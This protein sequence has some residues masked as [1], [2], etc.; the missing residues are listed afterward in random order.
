M[1][2]PHM[3]VRPI[4]YVSCMKQLNGLKQRSLFEVNTKRSKIHLIRIGIQKSLNVYL[5]RTFGSVYLLTNALKYV[6]CDG[7][8]E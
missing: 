7:F 4:L 3:S 1:K 2:I 8:G 5:K 6:H